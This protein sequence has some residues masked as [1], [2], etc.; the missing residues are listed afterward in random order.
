FG[1]LPAPC[2]RPPQLGDLASAELDLADFGFALAAFAFAS[3]GRDFRRAERAIRVTSI[4]G[5]FGGAHRFVGLFLVSPLTE[6]PS[7]TRDVDLRNI[8]QVAGERDALRRRGAPQ[9]AS[10]GFFEIPR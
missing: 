3:S 9:R 1:F 7:A 8:V 2:R 10:F 4:A 5:R 6:T